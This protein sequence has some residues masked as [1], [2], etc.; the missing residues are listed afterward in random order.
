[1]SAT[2]TL[3]L[4]FQELRETILE[5]GNSDEIKERYLTI[6]DEFP[7]LSI[8]DVVYEFELWLRAREDEERARTRTIIEEKFGIVVLRHG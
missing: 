2:G 5:Y 8:G 3:D 6:C 4:L 1:M 7:M